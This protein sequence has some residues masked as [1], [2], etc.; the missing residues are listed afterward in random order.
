MS[1]EAQRSTT[2]RAR[3]R[4]MWVR[5]LGLDDT[6]HNIALGV[7][8]G[9]VVAFQPIVGI[10]MVVSAVICKLVGANVAAGV[11][12][13][14]ITNPVTIAPIY[15]ATYRVG[16]LF[17][18]GAKTYADIERVVKQIFA[19]DWSRGLVEGYYL[20]ADIFWPTV[21]GGFIVGIT[22]AAVFYVLT[23]RAVVAYRKRRAED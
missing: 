9:I 2:W 23:R 4:A 18:G 15:Y 6:P 3:L 10:Q 8:I 13:A 16:V 14:W 22:I 1:G 19:L 21:I 7:A 20:L 5:L 11:P 17:T 12:W